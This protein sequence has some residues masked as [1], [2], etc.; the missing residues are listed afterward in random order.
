MYVSHRLSV[1]I[2]LFLAVLFCSV[3]AFSQTEAAAISGRVADPQGLAVSGAKVSAINTGTNVTT[4]T[5]TNGAGFYNLPSLI[6]GTYRVIVEK[7]GFAQIDRKS[8]V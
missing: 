4:S 5:Q 7:Q 2:F 3:P 6:P 1:P 8:V